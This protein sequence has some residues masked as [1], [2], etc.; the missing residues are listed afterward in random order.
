VTD[1]TSRDEVL[2]Y[3]VRIERRLGTIERD[4]ALLRAAVQGHAAR[5]SALEQAHLTPIPVDDSWGEP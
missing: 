4:L 3:L 2:A 1:C 5:V